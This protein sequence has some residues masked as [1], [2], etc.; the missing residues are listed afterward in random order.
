MGSPCARDTDQITAVVDIRSG[1]EISSQCDDNNGV[2]SCRL[3]EKEELE[4]AVGVAA[5]LEQD[6]AEAVSSLRSTVQQ[7]YAERVHLRR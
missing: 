5:T 3:R 2:L 6:A 4:V 7:M 1:R